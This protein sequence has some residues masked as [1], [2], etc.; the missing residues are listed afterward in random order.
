VSIRNVILVVQSALLGLASAISGK[1]RARAAAAFK[2]YKRQR[3]PRCS[4]IFLFNP[5]PTTPS[6]C[7]RGLIMCRLPLPT[8]TYLAYP[9]VGLAVADDPGGRAGL[10]PESSIYHSGF[11]TPK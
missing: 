9:F 3:S 8:Q 2:L 5:F 1:V 11:D 6:L 4:T 7:S 10:K